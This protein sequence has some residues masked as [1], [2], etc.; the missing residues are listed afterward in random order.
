M[1]PGLVSSL[2]HDITT[3]VCLGRQRWQDRPLH[4]EGASGPAPLS[5]PWPQC[6]VILRY[7]CLWPSFPG[8]QARLPG[9]PPDMPQQGQPTWL[10]DSSLA[11][12]PGCWLCLLHIPIGP[13]S[14]PT[15][16]LHS[17][18]WPPCHQGYQ[19]R[20]Q[21][22]ATT[23]GWQSCQDISSCKLHNPLQPPGRRTRTGSQPRCLGH[24]APSDTI[25]SH[26]HCHSHHRRPWVGSS[27]G[28]LTAQQG[29]LAALVLQGTR[30]L[31]LLLSLRNK[32][33]SLL[34]LTLFGPDHV[35]RS[36]LT[37]HCFWEVAHR[38][39][40]LRPGDS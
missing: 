2:S 22:P 16:R 12:S 35:M 29:F 13:S 36:L 11:P 14:A 23:A 3:H 20:S 28:Q 30:V 38:P 32:K 9:V 34:L 1:T 19:G 24:G 25:R 15:I 31:F 18:P 6:I 5:G 40:H 37:N 33:T 39:D 7:A 26:C 17:W 4:S 8:P 21:S 10:S 27:Q